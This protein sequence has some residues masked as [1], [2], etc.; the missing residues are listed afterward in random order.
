MYKTCAMKTGVW[1]K[2][3]KDTVILYSLFVSIFCIGFSYRFWL[4]ILKVIFFL[5]CLRNKIVE[6][7]KYMRPHEVY[8]TVVCGILDELK[9]YV[10]ADTL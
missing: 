8:G 2:Y 9:K 7:D 4:I 6:V 3:T 5:C 10:I 1:H